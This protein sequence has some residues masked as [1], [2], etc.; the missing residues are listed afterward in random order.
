M[1]RSPRPNARRRP[2]RALLRGL[3]AACVLA[4]PAAA[5]ADKPEVLEVV[6]TA[7]GEEGDER[8]YTFAVTIRHEDEGW[9]HYA[10]SFEVLDAETGRLLGERILLH[11]HVEEQP[12]TRELYRLPIDKAIDRVIIRARDEMVHGYGDPVEVDLPEAEESKAVNPS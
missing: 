10:T 9:R 8:F 6:V 3:I 4:A 11:P 5:L 1:H 2:F 12:F 7:A